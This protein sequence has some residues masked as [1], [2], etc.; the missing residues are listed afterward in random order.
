[1]THAITDHAKVFAAAHLGCSPDDVQ[2]KEVSGGYSR[3]RRSIV[4]S[5]EKRVFVKEVDIDLL[6]DEGETELAWLKKDYDLTK[7]LSRKGFDGISDWSELSDDGKVLLLPCYRPEDGWIW[8]FPEDE[9]LRKE[10]I[11]AVVGVT[12]HLEVLQIPDNDIETYAMEPFLRDEIGCDTGLDRLSQDEEMRGRV[13]AKLSSMI[14]SGEY[15]V[16]KKELSSTISL[17]ESPTQLDELRGSIGELQSQQNEYFGHCDVRS[18]N[19][20]YNIHTKQ[21]RLVDWN[22]ASMVPLNFGATEFL[23][24]ARKHGIDVSNWGA[25]LNHEL[26]AASVGFWLSRCLKEPL[27]PGSSLREMQA[28]SAAMAYDMYSR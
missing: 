16:A 13:I 25:Y 17:L 20:A 18:D 14:E 27:R 15:D 28:V 2:V 7:Y 9:L 5:G 22:W 11:G 24:D 10:Y 19:L 1:M 8:E 3:N 6:P 4:E 21:V 26:L 12:K 23:I